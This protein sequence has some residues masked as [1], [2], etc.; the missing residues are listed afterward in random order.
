MWAFNKLWIAISLFVGSLI[1]GVVGFSMVEGYSLSDAFYMAV[2]TFSTVGFQEVHPLS[3]QGRIFTGIYIIVNLGIFAYVI[4]V[5][6]TFIF[7]GELRKALQ[8]FLIGREVKK[9]KDHIIICGFGRN[10]AKAAEVL[11]SENQ[12]FVVIEKERETI[13]RNADNEKYQFVLGDSTNDDALLEAGIERARTLITTLPKDSDNVF[14]SLSARQLNPGINIIARA[15]DSESEKK[16]IRAGANRIVMPDYLGGIHMAQLTTKPYVI[17]F[18][19][20]LNG[21]GDGKMNLEEVTFSN[22]K[23]DIRNLSLKEMDVRKKTGAS[24]IA[25]KR[26]NN[27][28][29]FNP[30]SEDLI[31]ENDIMIVLATPENIQ[32]FRKTFCSS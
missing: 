32:R 25:I 3:N 6:S 31:K 13:N 21:V 24:I 4:S 9:M 15:S 27:K 14:I 10:G 18:L 2:I 22:L 17:E 19:D 30:A 8:D 16:L 23:N 1:L 7:E 12:K 26:A 28:F 29:L 11:F 20:M 5:F